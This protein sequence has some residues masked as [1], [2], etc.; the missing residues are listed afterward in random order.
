M[1]DVVDALCDYINNKC[2]N[3]NASVTRKFMDSQ[4]SS[5]DENQQLEQECLTII[6]IN[7]TM[8]NKVHIFEKEFEQTIKPANFKKI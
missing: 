3:I 4:E 1:F 7:K 2:E 8:F 6:R 5:N